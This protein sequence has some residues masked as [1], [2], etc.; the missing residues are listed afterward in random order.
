MEQT[1]KNL[2]TS[3]IIV[4]ALAV[5][6]L[7]NILF[8][9]FFGELNRELNSAAI[10]EGAPEN[11]V[12]IVRIF[13]SVVAVLLLLPHLYIGIKGLRIAKKPNSS[14]GHI[15]WGVIL[16][17]LTASGLISPLLALLR[18]NGDSFGNVSELLSISVDVFILFEYVKYA[19]AVRNEI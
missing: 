18:G 2:K 1:R 3:S 16:L 4:L 7:L 10:P 11:I 6:S 9:L 19:R 8:E 13:I 5:L 15:V 14:G 17:V 12:Q